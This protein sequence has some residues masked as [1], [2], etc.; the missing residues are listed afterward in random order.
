MFD[1]IASFFGRSRAVRE[2]AA[3]DDR[4]I[5]ELGLSRAELA[6]VVTA[7][8]AVTDRL[9]AMAARHGLGPRDL[10]GHNRDIAGM[11]ESCRACASVGACR[12]FLAAPGAEA[13]RA[14]F[15]PN[16]TTYEALRAAQ[17]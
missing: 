11:V 1:R 5:G 6:R 14:L 8:Q 9:R 12:A 15:C 7:P 4:A 13:A 17:T 2:V 16:H 10:A 3:L